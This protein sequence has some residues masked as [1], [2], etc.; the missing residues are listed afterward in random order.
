MFSSNT[1][2]VATSLKSDVKDAAHNAKRMEK[3]LESDSQDMAQFAHE[4]GRKVR[5]YF[6]VANDTVSQTADRVN[7]EINAHPMRSTLLALGAGFLIGALL[8][9]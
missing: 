8:R 3:S 9:R 2:E 6:E 7:D 1:K 5:D 4:A